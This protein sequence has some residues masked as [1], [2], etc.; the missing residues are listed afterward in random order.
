[1]D[2][3]TKEEVCLTCNFSTPEGSCKVANVVFSKDFSYYTKICSGPG[4]NIIHVQSAQVCF[5]KVNKLG[6]VVQMKI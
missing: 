5:I 2:V 3:I 6:G 4:P 1:M